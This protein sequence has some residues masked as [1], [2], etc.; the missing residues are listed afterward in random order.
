MKDDAKPRD[1][2]ERTFEFAQSMRAFR[3]ADD[4]FFFLGFEG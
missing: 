2:E 1:L 4:W 3:R